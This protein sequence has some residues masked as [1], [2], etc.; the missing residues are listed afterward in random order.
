MAVEGNTGMNDSRQQAGRELVQFLKL[1]PSND[2]GAQG[3]AD[4]LVGQLTE[5]LH[6]NSPLID[7]AQDIRVSVS[8]WFG[9]QVPPDRNTI[10][11]MRDE[12]ATRIIALQLA[13]ARK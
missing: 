8:A 10:T 12:L 1:G 7:Q 6:S 2:P 9:G 3:Q 4:A 5:G 13:I 11:R